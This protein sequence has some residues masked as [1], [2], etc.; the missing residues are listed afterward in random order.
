MISALI[1]AYNCR[2]WIEASLRSIAEQTLPAGEILVGDDASTDG[3]ADF[4]ESLGIPGVRVLRSD[5]NLGISF[6]LNRMI[7]EA[8]GRFLARMDGDDIAHPDRFQLQLAAM[9]RN[10]AGV[11]GAWSRRFGASDTVHRFAES[12]E[13][14]KAGL[15]F[16]VPFCHPTVMVDRD[17]LPAEMR[18]DSEFDLAED[19][20]L[21]TRLRKLTRYGNIPRI[22]LDWRMHGRNAGTAPATAPRQKLLSTRI[23]AGLFDEYGI[24]LQDGQFAVLDKRAMSMELDLQELRC[25]ATVLKILADADPDSIGTTPDAM[26]AVILEQWDLACAFAAWKHAETPRLWMTERRRLGGR[27]E[28]LVALKMFGKSLLGRARMRA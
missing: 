10:G 13:I 24:V 3:T 8:K 23:R 25:Y 22:L 20:H 21:W 12:D 14:L 15:L 28:S 18:Y 9:A 19:Y 11:M 6:Q 1:P 17:R 26:R 4:V 27:I 7:D 5:R 16:S 2:P